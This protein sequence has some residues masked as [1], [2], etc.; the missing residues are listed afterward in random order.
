L[1]HLESALLQ[2]NWVRSMSRKNMRKKRDGVK[3]L[4]R[5]VRAYYNICW[6][7]LGH[8][9]FSFSFA[10]RVERVFVASVSFSPCISV[11]FVSYLTISLSVSL[12]FFPSYSLQLLCVS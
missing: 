12:H 6:A 8:N 4:W 11:S 2:A 9:L 10:E 1:R 3:W 7:N 5:W